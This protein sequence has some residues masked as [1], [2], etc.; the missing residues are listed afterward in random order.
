MRKRERARNAQN[1]ME[2]SGSGM[3]FDTHPSCLL[4]YVMFDVQVITLVDCLHSQTSTKT[5][6]FWVTHDEFIDSPQVAG[7]HKPISSKKCM[8]LTISYNL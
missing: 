1:E 6:A 3:L 7:Y 4:M 5:S 2:V 8:V